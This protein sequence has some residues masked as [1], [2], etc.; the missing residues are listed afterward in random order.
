MLARVTTWEGGTAEGIRAATQQMQANVAK[1]PPEGIKS[2]GMTMLVAPDRGT[3]LMIGLFEGE[4]ELRESEP[5]F[6]RM[7]PP[8]GLGRR[9][10]TDMYEVAAD[11]RI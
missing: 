2:T 5:T 4:A 8:E 6:K 3:V 7:D 9:T 11:V 1:G 10:A